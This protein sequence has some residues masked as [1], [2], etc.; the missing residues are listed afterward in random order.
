M[1]PPPPEGFEQLP[2]GMN[3][4]DEFSQFMSQF[5]FPPPNGVPP[6]GTP[7]PPP[8]GLPPGPIP[9]DQIPFGQFLQEHTLNELIPTMPP[10]FVHGAFGA[11]QFGSLPPPPAGFPPFPPPPEFTGGFGGFGPPPADFPPGTAPPPGTPGFP[12]GLPPG[13]PEQ[14]YAFHEFQGDLKGFLAGIDFPPLPPPPGEPGGPVP[15]FF[16]PVFVD[17]ETI[18]DLLP[19]SFMPPEFAAAAFEQFAQNNPLIGTGNVVNPDLER[20]AVDHPPIPPGLD[21]FDFHGDC[22]QFDDLFTL[23]DQ[24]HVGVPMKGQVNSTMTEILAD[25]STLM[26]SETTLI[27]VVLGEALPFV[28][29][30][31]GIIQTQWVVDVHQIRNARFLVQPP[32]DPG[33]PVESEQTTESFNQMTWTV[34]V[35]E[36]DTDG[37]GII[38]QVL[39]MGS[40]TVE[41]IE[42]TVTGEAPDGVPE[43]PPLLQ[44]YEFDTVLEVGENTVVADDG[45][46][47]PIN[48]TPANE[49]P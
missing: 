34:L 18:A 12:P 49:N 24:N 33:P 14:M 32:D 6:D 35:Q 21:G 5:G 28:D 7:P 40:N 27:D 44:V 10:P 23:Y 1:L 30:G 9:F 20:A 17:F 45:E 15:P 29:M 4:G 11:F 8:G 2:P 13:L 37:D 38:D 43:P 48:D 3:F 26:R 46:S 42:E 16:V 31:D 41:K 25:G 39:T 36:I 19:P 22:P 47:A